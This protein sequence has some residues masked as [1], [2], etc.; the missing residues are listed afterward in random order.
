MKNGMKKKSRPHKEK[1]SAIW[2]A[3]DYCL[4]LL[5]LLSQIDLY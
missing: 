1:R 3:W 4:M 2:E 5:N